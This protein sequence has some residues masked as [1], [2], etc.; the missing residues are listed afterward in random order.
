[1]SGRPSAAELLATPGALIGVEHLRELGHDE[2][3]IARVLHGL[4]EIAFPSNR[5]VA[6]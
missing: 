4:P 1:M 2:R 6:N 3:T 5:T